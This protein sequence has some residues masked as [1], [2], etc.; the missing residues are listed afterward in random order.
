MLLEKICF[1]FLFKSSK[2]TLITEIEGQR[3]LKLREKV[4]Y[5]SFPSINKLSTEIR[6]QQ[7]SLTRSSKSNWLVNT[8]GIIE[9]LRSE[10]NTMRNLMTNDEASV[11]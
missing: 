10:F 11:K 8:D 5:I 1:Q 2:I 9:V 4:V 6:S 3:I 7:N